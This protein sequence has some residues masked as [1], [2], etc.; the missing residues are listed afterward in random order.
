MR[1]LF[2]E[3]DPV[4]AAVLAQHDRHGSGWALVGDA[5]HFKD[6]LSTHGIIDA[7]RDS[8]FLAE[9]TADTVGGSVPEVEAFGRYQAIRDRLSKE[10][11][12]ATEVVSSYDWAPSELR[13]LLLALSAAMH[14]EVAVLATLGPKPAPTSPDLSTTAT[15]LS[16]VAAGMVQ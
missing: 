10:R 16:P 3:R 2:L 8:E 11:S 1:F 14:D 7:L 6:P 4:G 12:T 5:S 9:A 15:F 13:P